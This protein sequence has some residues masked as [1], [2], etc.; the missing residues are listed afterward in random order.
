MTIRL[1]PEL[2]PRINGAI[3]PVLN[4]PSR[5]AHGKLT[6]NINLLLNLYCY[7]SSFIS[8]LFFLTSHIYLLLF[9]TTVLRLAL[10]L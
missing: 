5:R 3:K 6:T 9:I 4:T 8:N 2:R 10:D 1:H 7:T